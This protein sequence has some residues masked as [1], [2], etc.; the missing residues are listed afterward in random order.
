MSLDVTKP[1]DPRLAK[2]HGHARRGEVLQAELL[3]QGILADDPGCADAARAVASL[4]AQRE[5]WARARSHYQLALRSEP[6]DTETQLELAQV[7]CRLDQPDAAAALL[8]QAVLLRPDQPLAW[9]LLGDVLDLMGH[10]LA[11]T[12]AHYQ[13]ITRAH[14]LGQWLDFSTV[15]PTLVEHV[16]RIMA[17]VTAGRRAHLLQSFEA[18]RTEF[19][20]RSVDRV[21]RA[22]W[23]YLGE[24]DATPPDPRQ[25]PKFL[26]V[27]GL[28]DQ[29]YHDP[30]LQPWASALA[31]HWED[32]RTEALDLLGEHANFESFLG[33]KAGEANADYVAGSGPNPAWDAFFFY[34]HGKRFDA[35]HARCPNTSALLESIT[36]CRVKNQ[37]PEVCFSVIRPGSRIMPHYG[38]TNSRLVM[39][40]PLVVPADCALNII[41]GGEHRWREGELMMFDDTFRHEAWNHS[42]QSRVILLMDCWNPHLSAAEQQAIRQL[43]EAIDEF[44]SV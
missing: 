16:T 21:E 36:L 38:V 37:A 44:E 27:P 32:L 40:L 39:H 18:T 22:L 2:A 35:N 33:L 20:A 9:L 1:L 6:N 29:P 42:G 14:K 11:A 41:D 7:L 28:P 25:R 10:S 5:D 19:G 3:Y 34:R 30:M 43:V 26:Y 31:A 15:H 8:R 13:A 17:S 4:A 24:I 12:K 23:G